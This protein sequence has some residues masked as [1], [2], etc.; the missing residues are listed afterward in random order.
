MIVRA[1]RPGDE[2]AIFDLTQAAFAPMPFSGGTEGPIIDA[3]RRDG[4]LVLSLVAEAD[5]AIVGH[6]AFSPVTVSG[7]SR[8]LYGLGPVSAHPERQRQGIGSALIREGL[9]RLPD[10]RAVFLVGDPAYYSRFGFVGDCG[11]THGSVP[12]HAV[13]GL[14]LD[15]R[16]RSGEIRY[17]PGFAAR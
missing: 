13:Q 9:S 1:E 7:E 11:L 16:A 3:L 2:A 17:A 15:G 10:A 5:A 8:G 12:P 6:I 4:D 14:F